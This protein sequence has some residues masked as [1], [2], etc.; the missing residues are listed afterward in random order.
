[1]F[2]GLSSECSTAVGRLAGGGP[3]EV[4]LGFNCTPLEGV[5][6]HELGH[7][8]GFWHEHTRPDRDRYVEILYS[9]I[10]EEYHSNFNIRQAEDIDSLGLPYDLDSIMHYSLDAFSNNQQNTIRVKVDFQGVVGQR[11]FLSDKDIQQANL[12]YK[13]QGR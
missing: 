6:M 3:Q 5:A 1:M 9:N 2:S 8:I 13:C 11:L 7:S 4:R 12:L 10:D